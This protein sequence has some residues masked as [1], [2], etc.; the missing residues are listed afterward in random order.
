MLL[1]QG[2]MLP[3]L[4][5]GAC[6]A[7]RWWLGTVA[8]NDGEWA[9]G[10]RVCGS[11]L[12]ANNIVVTTTTAAVFLASLPSFLELPVRR[13]HRLPPCVHVRVHAIIF[14]PHPH[15]VSFEVVTRILFCS[16]VI[17]FEP[18][19]NRHSGS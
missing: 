19:M 11:A 5:V 8:V 17:P 18:H 7:I 14:H 3:G 6:V 10:A 16:S 12:G 1:G 13:L 2:E 9:R 15:N 4:G